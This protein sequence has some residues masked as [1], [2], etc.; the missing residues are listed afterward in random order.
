R[1][2]GSQGKK[3]TDA[4][5]ADVEVSDESN[6]KPT[7]K[8]TSSR[9]VIKKKVSISTDDNIIPDPDVALKLGK[10]MS[11]TEAAEEEATRQVHATHERIVT[12]S[13]PEP[14]RRRPSGISFKDNPSMSKKLSPD[15]S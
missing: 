15:P 13:D 7:R 11:L 3:T 1:D 12:E 4:P 5:Q 8:Q 6:S 2:K 10:S 14:A 9:R